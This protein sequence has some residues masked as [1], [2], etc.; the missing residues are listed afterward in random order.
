MK[1][2]ELF[3]EIIF[4]NLFFTLMIFFMMIL[5]KIYILPFVFY[6]IFFEQLNN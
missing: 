4:E 2:E 1:N 5:K 3:F 6:C